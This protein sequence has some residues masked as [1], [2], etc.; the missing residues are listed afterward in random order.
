MK[1][2]IL[3]LAVLI[4]SHSLFAQTLKLT[5][6]DGKI[7]LSVNDQGKPNYE[8]SFLGE[9]IIQRSRLGLAFKDTIAFS[10]GFTISSSETQSAK[11]VWQLPWG[12]R[13]NVTDE[14]NELLVTFAINNRTETKKFKVRFR[15]FN[16]GVG[17]RY[18]VPKQQ[19]IEHVEIINEFTEFVINDADKATAWWIPARGWNRY[20]YIYNTT[21]L[22]SV[23]RAHTPFTFKLDS[24]T[25][26]S[27]HEAALVDYAAMT[28]NQKRP[29]V[30]K[31]NLTPWSDGVLVKTKT[32]FKSPWR[33]IQISKDA[34]GLLNSDLILNLNEPNKLG[35]VSWVEPAKYVGIW[36]GM[37]INA[38]TWGS[39]E[40]HGATTSET[41]RYIDFAAEHG[42]AGVLVEGWNLGWDGDWF[43]NG[44]VFNFSKAYD[45][46]DIAAIS[47]YG[48]K[49]GVRLI[50]HHET[51]GNVTNY[52]NQMNDAY[53]LYEK[54]G[55]RQVK[56]GYVADGG[57]IKRIDEHGIIRKEWHD[58]QFMV[59][60]YLHSITEAA[61]HKIS[62]NT[63]EPIKA[64]GLRRTYPNWISR[65]GARGQEFN[66]WGTPPNPPEHTTILPFTRML[67]GPMDFTP[68]IFD[69]SF[70]GLGDKSNRPQT[71]LAKQ[72]ALYVVLYSPIQMAADLPK[73]YQANLAAFQFIKDV[74]TDWHE[75]IAI[76]GEVG[77]Y[78]AF[79]RQE[80]GG[81]DWFVG[82]LT[83]E[84]ARTLTLPLDF[85][86]KNKRYQAQIY[87][88]GKNAEWINN[89]Y[90]MII[91]SKQV[92]ANDQLVLPLATSGGAAIRFK[93]L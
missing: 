41:M 49:K 58:G 54:H 52:R 3:S 22:A 16:D 65:E 29:G 20:E 23:D 57:D 46:F 68:G 60:E 79:A 74:P 50:G 36:W 88:D 43:F 39:G 53:A 82:A 7:I 93:A 62:I 59:S 75:S 27:I 34:V 32:H 48:E 37:H 33:T 90:E 17:F 40:K 84:Q 14:H 10:D 73:N 81:D 67:A 24:G 70:N 13:K 9:S 30:L 42:F 25:H 47:A 89:P 64:T 83:D 69:M 15:L 2:I 86:D 6:P 87:R 78:V 77:E 85:L 80:S 55:V 1:K 91:E 71:T 61:K 45:D 51:S 18:E 5:S 56:T 63:H 35:D 8:M 44:D 12:E 4:S 21:K 72:L 92:T 11:E 66:A 38:N 19:D 28:I 26:L 76:A 31:A